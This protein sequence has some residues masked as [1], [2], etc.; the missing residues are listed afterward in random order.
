M[1]V[2]LFKF[3]CEHDCPLIVLQYGWT[4]LH[5]AGFYG[6]AEM[7]VEMTSANHFGLPPDK[8]NKVR[9]WRQ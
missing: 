5:L 4:A 3:A 8:P 6:N 7:V 9:I 1:Y 2:A